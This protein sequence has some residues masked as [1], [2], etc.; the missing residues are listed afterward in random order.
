MADDYPISY[1]VTE[2]E[3]ITKEEYLSR[4]EEGLPAY[5]VQEIMDEGALNGFLGEI[6]IWNNDNGWTGEEDYSSVSPG[7]SINP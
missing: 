3:F 7:G 5:T 2:V 1:N 6:H 4:K